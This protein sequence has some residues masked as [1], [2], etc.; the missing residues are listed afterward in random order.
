MPTPNANDEN[1][2]AAESSDN[3]NDIIVHVDD[4]ADDE[5]ANA[6]QEFEQIK[7]KWDDRP[8]LGLM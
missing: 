8:W 5:E 4:A 3:D 6:A 1:Q 2:D 7:T